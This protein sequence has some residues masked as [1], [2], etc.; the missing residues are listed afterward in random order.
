MRACGNDVA[1]VSVMRRSQPGV[2]VPVT[3][4]TGPGLRQRMRSRT[5]GVAESPRWYLKEWWIGLF[6]GALVVGTLCSYLISV[7]APDRCPRCHS[8]HLAKATTS[9]DTWLYVCSAC[10]IVWRTKYSARPSEH[11]YEAHHHHH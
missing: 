4:S 3:S 11:H 9:T 8:A 5:L 2:P 1:K 10:A 6:F 7:R